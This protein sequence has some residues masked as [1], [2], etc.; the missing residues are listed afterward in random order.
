MITLAA[1]HSQSDESALLLAD[2]F[3][4]AAY[5]I[6]SLHNGMLP[7]HLPYEG[8]LEDQIDISSDAIPALLTFCDWFLNAT[9]FHYGFSD[10]FA[11]TDSF[12]QELLVIRFLVVTK[13]HFGITDV[14]IR[15]EHSSTSADTHKGS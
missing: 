10:L 12:K 15:H 4:A 2:E 11:D 1:L 13:I 3:H 14:S 7:C 9:C 8:G 5:S 6:C